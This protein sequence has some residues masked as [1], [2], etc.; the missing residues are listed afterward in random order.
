MSR[1]MGLCDLMLV[2]TEESANTSHPAEIDCNWNNKITTFNLIPDEAQFS[3][4]ASLVFHHMGTN[5]S[6]RIFAEN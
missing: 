4:N 5:N 2:M 6:K 3:H 1:I